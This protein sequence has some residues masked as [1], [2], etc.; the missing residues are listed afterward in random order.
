MKN[1]SSS[2]SNT[3]LGGGPVVSD[4]LFIVVP[5]HCGGS[6]FG[7]CYDFSNLCRFSFA[8]ILME[9]R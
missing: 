5:S 1:E 4:S 6:V 7:S 9:K 8:I 2:S 3:P